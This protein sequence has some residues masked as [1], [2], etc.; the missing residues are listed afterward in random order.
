[1]AE[2]QK[3]QTNNI[4]HRIVYSK[5]FLFSFSLIIIIFAYNMVGIIKHSKE[6]TKEKDLAL[7]KVIDLKNEQDKLN[8]KIESLKSDIGIEENIRD[9]FHLALP[10]EGLVVI[11]EPKSEKVQESTGSGFWQTIKAFFYK[12]P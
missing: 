2:F 3:K 1:M 5:V 4:W 8:T 9:K 7:E 11:V 12:K 10:G 6:A